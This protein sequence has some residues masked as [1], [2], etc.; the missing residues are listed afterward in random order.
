MLRNR[1]NETNKV[2]CDNLIKIAIK[3]AYK[4]LAEMKV[5]DH[6]GPLAMKG[7]ITVDDT[8]CLSV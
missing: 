6:Q 3:A 8:N 4:A 5:K 7:S 2:E 1:D